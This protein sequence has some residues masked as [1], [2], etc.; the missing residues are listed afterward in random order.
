MNPSRVEYIRRKVTLDPD[1]EPPWTFENRFSSLK[2]GEGRGTGRW[3]DGRECLDV[4]CG[5]GLLSE[6]SDLS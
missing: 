5:G 4:G 6:V 2:R 3:L 1:D